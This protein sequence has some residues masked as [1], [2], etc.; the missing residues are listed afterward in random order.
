MRLLP[1][2][3]RDA[4]AALDLLDPTASARRG[5]GNLLPHVAAAAI[6]QPEIGLLPVAG[7]VRDADPDDI[8][9]A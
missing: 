1:A 2:R 5:V 8:E 7:V 9:T 4:Q 3:S 6:G